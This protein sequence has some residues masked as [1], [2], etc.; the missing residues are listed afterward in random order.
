[1]G[2]LGNSLGREVVDHKGIGLG[3]GGAEGTGG[4]IFAVVAGEHGDDNTRTG[5]LGAAEHVDV[6]GS[7]VDLFD[8]LGLKVG[9]GVTIAKYALDAA[10]PGLLQLREVDL[11]IGGLEHI[12]LNGSAKRLHDNA[13]GDIAKLGILGKLNDKAAVHRGEEA[14]DI[15]VVGKLEAKLVAHAHLEEALGAAAIAGRGDG[16]RGARGGQAL[17]KLKHVDELGCVGTIILAVD[18]RRDAYHA[19][20]SGL[21][22]GGDGARGTAH[23]HGEADERR[24]D[25]ELLTVL[26]KASAHGVLATDGAGT[27]VDLGHQGAKDRGDRLAPALGLGTQALEVLLERE[28][29]LLMLETCGNELGR[30]LYDGEVG[31]GKLV[32]LHEEG[33]EAPGHGR[34]RGGFAVY[35]ELGDHS[36]GR[37]ELRLAA[38]GHEHGGGADGG[39]KALGE[40]LVGGDVEVGDERGHAFGERRALPAGLPHAAGDHMGFL[41]LGCAVGVEELAGEVDDGYTVPSHAHAR[42]LGDLGD[43]GGLEVFFGGIAHELLD[44]LVGHGAC[45]TLLRLGDGEF[46]A[47][48]ALVL[49]GHHV[50]VDVQAVGKLAHGDGD[51][52][53]AKVVAALDQAAGVATTEQTLELALDRGVALLHLGAGSLDGVGVLRLGRTGGAA[54]AVTAGA[55]AEQDDLVGGCGALAAHMGSRSGAHDG[56]HLHALGGVTGVI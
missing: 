56:A 50:E 7:K 5:D 2:A 34:C 46:G 27:E 40:T 17:D 15:H 13:L 8:R 45:H 14:L 23:G 44:V 33:V 25:V 36:L 9:C 41:M 42:L 37:R 10:L 4:V 18:S 24:R 47:I 11:L 52:A 16:E 49:L 31:A 12:A 53:C 29:R 54:D 51:A 21:E 38:E 39:V 30:A 20:A 28:V 43:D 3:A 26:L 19:V 6:L 55:A 22:L 35:G 32:C 1:M 48:E